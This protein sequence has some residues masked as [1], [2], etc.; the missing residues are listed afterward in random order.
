M[1]TESPVRAL[2]PWRNGGRDTQDHPP[3]AHLYAYRH[4]Y[5]RAYLHAYSHSYAHSHSDADSDARTSSRAYARWGDTGG[6]DSHPYVP[7][8]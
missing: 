7:L 8:H 1:D 5:A 3:D 2:Q 4:P 6:G